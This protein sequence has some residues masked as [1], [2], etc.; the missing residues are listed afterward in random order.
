MKSYPD[1][2]A[3]KS[4][5]VIFVSLCMLFAVSRQAQG[6]ETNRANGKQQ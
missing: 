4:G 3:I 5:C 2:S 6:E 1:R